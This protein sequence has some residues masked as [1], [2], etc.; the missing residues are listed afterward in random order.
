MA[1]GCFCWIIRNKTHNLNME[2]LL[3]GAS[4]VVSVSMNKGRYS[5]SVLWFNPAGT[6][7]PLM[8]SSSS[9]WDGEENQK[10]KVRLMGK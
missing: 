6:T 4:G 3:S 10:N 8:R 2:Q 1:A 7:Q 9:Q 5:V